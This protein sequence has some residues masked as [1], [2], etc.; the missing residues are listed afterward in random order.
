MK[1]IF[2][3]LVIEF[4]NEVYVHNDPIATHRNVLKLIE[5]RNKSQSQANAQS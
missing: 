1:K 5:E 2:K 3:D 4:A